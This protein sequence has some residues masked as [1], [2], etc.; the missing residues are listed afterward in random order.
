MFYDKPIRICF[1]ILCGTAMGA[2][3]TRF[4]IP[5]GWLIG[6][7]FTTALLSLSGFRVSIIPYG[8]ELSQGLVGIAAGLKLSPQVLNS[9]LY[10]VP[11]MIAAS[12]GLILFASVQSQLISRLTGLDPKTTFFSSFPGGVAEMTVLADRYGGDPGLVSIAQFLRILVVTLS[13]PQLVAIFGDIGSI[14]TIVPD[15]S[16]SVQFLLVLCALGTLLGIFLV[17]YRIPNSWL[18]A[19]VLTGSIAGASQ[20]HVA[21]VPSSLLVIA[22]IIIGVALGSRCKPTILQAGRLFL[23]VNAIGTVILVTFSSATALLLQM[24]T[25]ASLGSLLLAM[26]PGGIAEMSLVATTLHYDIVVVV[27][28]HLIRIVM[29]ILLSVP[30]MKMFSKPGKRS[31]G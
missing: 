20:I 15:T 24:L 19:G 25:G 30:L 18:L 23:P 11:L 27:A 28:F 16:G 17:R 26:A 6:A 2:L 7:L 14:E 21:P 8:R 4:H 22:Q 1:V 3:A 12:L 9:L 13:V 31:E 5:L 29:V 10:M